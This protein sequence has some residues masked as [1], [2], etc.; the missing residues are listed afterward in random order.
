MLLQPGLEEFGGGLEFDK[1][2][3]GWLLGILLHGWGGVG[4]ANILAKRHDGCEIQLL[5]GEDTHTPVF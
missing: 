1:T 2:G 3:W 4:G 5:E